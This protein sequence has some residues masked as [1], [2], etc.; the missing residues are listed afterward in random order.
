M[1]EKKVGAINFQVLKRKQ[2]EYQVLM[3][4]NYNQH[5]EHN[6]MAPLAL[7]T[8]LQCWASFQLVYLNIFSFNSRIFLHL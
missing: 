3:D 4:S 7:I 1:V 8:A 5:K 2:Y 6:C